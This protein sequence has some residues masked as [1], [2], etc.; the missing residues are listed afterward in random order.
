MAKKDLPGAVSKVVVTYDDYV[1][2]PDDGKRYEIID[3]DVHVTPA[4]GPEHQKVV[5]KLA[6]VLD[7]HVE[8]HDLGDIYI[9]PFDVVLDLTNVV[10][11]DIIF[12][13]KANAH[14][15]GRALEGAPDLAVETLSP[16]TRRRDRTVKRL[17][18][19]SHRVPYLWFVDP[20]NR[21][22]EELT[23]T[24]GKYRVTAKLEGAAVFE[25]RAFPGLEIPLAKVW[26]KKRS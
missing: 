7:D 15:I 5:L 9:A 2:F 4:P 24:K 8:S 12:V 21:S 26:P 6:K 18:Y 11:P 3:G 1:E 10:Q 20:E 17:A 13:A 16:S 25:P 23:L 14:R 22:V 19:E